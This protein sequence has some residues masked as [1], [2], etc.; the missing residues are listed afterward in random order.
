[1][2]DIQ[3]AALA[4]IGFAGFGAIVVL[5]GEVL[6]SRRQRF[7][8]RPVS[9]AWIGSVLAFVSVFF[10]VL[11]AVA[12]MQAY[13]LGYALVFNPDNPMIRIDRFASF[14]ITLVALASALSCLLSVAYLAT[15]RINHGEYYALLLLATS[16]MMLLIASTDLIT[17]FLGFELMSIPLYALAGFDR[18]RV[19][20]NESALKYFLVGAFA[21]AILL[22]GMALLYGATG[23]TDFNGLRAALD[24]GSPLALAGLA[25]VLVGFAF[26]VAA[27]PFHQWAPDVYEGA[28]TSVT[29]YMSVTVKV[30]AFAAL[31]R[32]L[33]S[34]VGPAPENLS[35]VLWGLAAATL[36]LGN[37][38][39]VV[40]QNVKRLLAYSSIAH[41]GYV[42]MGLVSGTEGGQA[43]V[44][45]YLLAYV[46]MNLGAFAVIVA[47]ARDG[48]DFDRISDFAGLSRTRP[49]LAGLMTLFMLSLAGIPPTAGFF[50]KFYIFSAAVD[51]GYLWL[52]VIA[53]L[54]TVVSVYYY[55][56]LPVAMYMQEPSDEVPR[57]E[58]S[59]G[60]TLVLAVCAA[61]VVFFGI[62]P[63]HAPG[64]LS[65]IRALD[66]ARESVAFLF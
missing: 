15:L 30:A 5:M 65:G 51:A 10:L 6:L 36:L 29:A 41:A 21:S 50:A 16:G 20:S 24:F 23:H 33:G 19:R 9:D 7:L 53:V 56:R 28:P 1:M 22:Y 26:K 63:S 32:L 40:Q 38:M 27:V 54:T 37:L 66:W 61:G 3:L 46:F 58:T 49:G 52:T 39:A 4:P 34:A 57:A 18:S 64:M 48:Q 59:T 31:L 62:F 11:S 55:L 47:L 14:G 2:P 8:G 43:A 17:V 42:L 44:L 25:L 35:G 12:S 60:E 45:F 13:S